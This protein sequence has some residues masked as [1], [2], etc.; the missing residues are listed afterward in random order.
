MGD[1]CR[2]F[3]TPVTGGNV[4]FYNQTVLENAAEPVFP[5]PT[6][7]MLGVLDNIS[8]RTTIR[9]KNEGDAIY[10][11]G[12]PQNDIG[13]SEYVKRVHDVRF[14]PAP[15]F[16]LDEEFHIQHNMKLIIKKGFVE[17]AHDV[18][19]GGLFVSLVES[20]MA[21]NL[22]FAVETDYNFRK[23]AYLFG[24]SQ[25]RIVITVKSD[26]ED[27]LVNYL[28]SHNVSF[29]KLGEVKGQNAIVDEKD[30]GPIADWRKLYD[31][32]LG[33]IIEN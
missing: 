15:A 18:S 33:E 14:S 16:D 4:S 8:Q 32:K 23:D 2:K 21:G 5:T 27:D 28:N 9:F 20:A 11:L 22:G 13:S 25:S 19:E 12:T 10:M 3:N 1:A 24:E 6:I 7:G 17:S 31:N 26:N 29:T 30:F